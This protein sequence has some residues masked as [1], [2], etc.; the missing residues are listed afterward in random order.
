MA[1]ER[2]GPDT[3]DLQTHPQP[4]WAKGLVE[5]ARHPSR[6]YSIWVNGNETFYFD[7]T[8]VQTQ[9]LVDLFANSRL[10][11]HLVV[12]KQ[13]RTTVQT[14]GKQSIPYNVSLQI[15]EGIAL[16]HTRRQ[17]INGHPAPL[18]MTPVLT[19]Y[20]D[21]VSKPLSRI[22]SHEN[23]V[24]QNEIQGIE[25]PSPKKLPERKTYH[26][27][28]EFKDGSPL[29]DFVT[30]MQGQITLWEEGE[31][32]GIKMDKVS[33]Q[34][35]FFCRFS[36][37]EMQDLKSGESFLTWTIG[38]YL[39]KPTRQ[40]QRFPIERL[41]LDA[42]Q[43]VRL[44][45]PSPDYHWGRLL[46]EDNQP[47]ILDPLPWPGAKISISMPYANPSDIDADGFFRVLISPEQ[48]QALLNDKV[49]K[50]VYIPSY[51]RKGS[52]RAQYTF[53]PDLLHPDKQQAGVL[54]I[55]R[56]KAPQSE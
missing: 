15:V 28:M 7:A 20:V 14:F 12:L 21:V 45:I 19:V 36:D 31:A 26:G 10:R 2:L 34:G 4:G 47:P 13:P 24:I 29:S 52:S 9:E 30:Q 33:N 53:S 11:D 8:P 37:Q 46:F 40:D 49:G 6:V 55:P 38:N 27:A 22:P 44:S 43:V 17:F 16:W 41:A 18:P 1:E 56:V 39:V 5:L 3:E 25:V 35:R 54:R 51:E 42:D 32:E 50:N 48:K 23:I